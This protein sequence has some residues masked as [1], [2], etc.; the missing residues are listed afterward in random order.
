MKKGQVG[1]KICKK[2]L[3]FVQVVNE[4]GEVR[5][6]GWQNDGGVIGKLTSASMEEIYNGQTARLIRERHICHDFSNCNPNSCP[7]VANNNV[8]E[9]EVEIDEIPKL[10]YSLYLA[11][12]NVC[13]YHCVMCTI[14]DCMSKADYQERERKLNIVDDEIRKVLPYVRKIGAHG[15]GELFAS[16]HILKLLSEWKPLAAPEECYVE[17]ES[18]A[19][20]F[21]EEN[22]KKI[23]NLGQ[24]NLTV[25]ITVL[26]FD[27]DVYRELSGT[28]LHVNN[29]IN[30]L[31]FI[32]K[33]REQ[34]IINHLVIATVYQ[35]KNFRSLPEFARRA[36]EEFGADYV[37]LRPFEPW[38]EVTMDEWLRDVRNEYHPNHQEFLE[39]MKDP[40][41]HHPKVHDWGGGKVSGLGKEP[42]PR[43]RARY[44]MIESIYC[45]DSFLGKVQAYVQDK[46]VVVYGMIAVGKALAVRLK[47]KYTVAYCIDKAMDGQKYEEIPIYSVNHLDNLSRDVA[48]IVTL[49]R[50]EEAVIE[51]LKKNGYEH[52][53]SIKEFM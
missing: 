28:H 47:D 45:D 38:R 14:P 49:D 20:L 37:R 35:N 1:M 19:S 11:Y 41:L 26:S 44:H 8:E 13:N 21:T 53:I 24:Y 18:N 6:C 40:M 36:I 3:E 34:G 50:N 25:Y 33:L 32:K 12:E 29:V 31:R 16:R 10:P 4:D 22:W 39:I 5:I 43:T 27:D 9:N 30:N 42:Y 46:P 52:C 7:F 2:A 15:L 48:V 23:E 51:T 17:L